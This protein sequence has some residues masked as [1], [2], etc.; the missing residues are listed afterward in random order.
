[1]LTIILSILLAC[2]IL[3]SSF[4]SATETALF[5]LPQFQI[6][7]FARAK[8]KNRNL[9]SALLTHPRKLLVTILIL[10]ISMNILVQNSV[11]AIFDGFPGWTVSVFLPLILTLIFGELIP[12]AI[13]IS[14][15]TKIA[16]AVAPV[17]FFLQWILR[18]LRNAVLW[19]TDH[20]SSFLFFFLKKEKEISVSEII[21]ALKTSRDYG[22]LSSEEAKLMRGYL[23]LE[24]LIVKEL[25]SPR[26]D[27]IYFD[28]SNSFQ[29]LLSLFVDKECT[30]I[31]VCEGGKENI[32]GVIDSKDMFLHQKEI[33]DVQQLKKYLQKPYYIPESMPAKL[34][35][36]QF[37]TMH[38]HFAVVVDEYGSV[39]GIVTKEDLI[40]MVVGQ[41]DDKRDSSTSYTRSGS[42]VMIANG[43]LELSEFE[44]IFD[45]PLVS[46]C[47]MA[48]LGGWL[49]EKMG[50][51][52]KTGEKYITQ[53]FLFHI[54]SSTPS[55]IESIY[56]RKLNKRS[57]RKGRKK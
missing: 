17:I 1:M 23:G 34:L 18:P 3:G 27:M 55:H 4:L 46:E 36:N 28:L 16:T 56:V 8:N 19:L 29:E 41:I 2:F 11:S 10:N 39:S 30:R 21:H 6:R 50:D 26:N 52:P 25:M 48:T 31:P 35:F 15:N 54:L 38:W 51:I 32:I 37:N 12:K 24:E 33:T 7:A 9:V 42:D 40:E 45:I 57:A 49:T 5:S 43:K 47:N 44:A 22:V 20:I 13:A 14:N 53:Q